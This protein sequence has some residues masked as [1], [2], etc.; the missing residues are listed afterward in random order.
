MEEENW[1]YDS[2]ASENITNLTQTA[3]IVLK[4]DKIWVVG[5]NF[6]RS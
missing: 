5:L 6:L 4:F 2:Y 1:T 3:S